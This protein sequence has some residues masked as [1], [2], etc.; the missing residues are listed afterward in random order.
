MAV[1]FCG[2]PGQKHDR[3]S[4]RKKKV[5]KTN[6]PLDRKKEKCK[7]KKRKTEKRKGKKWKKRGRKE[8][9]E[10]YLTH[11]TIHFI[12]AAFERKILL[13]GSLRN[14]HLCPVP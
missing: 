12:V 14:L 8:G 13:R 11:C 7:K 6:D 10:M 5:E 1:M 4:E 9:R 3:M 2:R